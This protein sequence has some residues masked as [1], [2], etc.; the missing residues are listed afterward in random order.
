MNRI[1]QTP[2]LSNTLGLKE[3]LKGTA[4]MAHI[5]YK[6][7]FCLLVNL[8]ESCIIP[9]TKGTHPNYLRWMWHKIKHVTLSTN[10]WITTTDTVKC[11][12]RSVSSKI[13]SY[14]TPISVNFYRCS[15]IITI[16]VTPRSSKK[17]PEYTFCQ[18]VQI[19]SERTHDVQYPVRFRR[20][21]VLTTPEPEGLS[22]ALATPLSPLLQGQLY[23]Y[24][25]I[26]YE[27]EFL[28]WLNQIPNT[29]V[30]DVIILTSTAHKSLL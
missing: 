18:K 27:M 23:L 29:Y 10:C 20:P 17:D 30:L 3:D 16:A 22:E 5:R 6:V 2:Q 4:H 28:C 8:K 13:M 1:T 26:W 7:T 9:L 15:T 14:S 12:Q 21:L 19:Q 11:Q 25:I 24:V